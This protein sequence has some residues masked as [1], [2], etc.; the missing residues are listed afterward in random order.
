MN[1]PAG[2]TPAIQTVR[3]AA[4]GAN[5]R[6]DPA[7]MRLAINGLCSQQ[8]ALG[9]PMRRSEARRAIHEQ[10]ASGE[11]TPHEVTPQATTQEDWSEDF[12]DPF[13]PQS[14]GEAQVEHY[15]D[16]TGYTGN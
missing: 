7:L 6:I 15:R 4:Q 5:A 8:A 13:G 9:K 11:L 10:I 3:P 2:A 12:A 16:Q 1:R 14:V